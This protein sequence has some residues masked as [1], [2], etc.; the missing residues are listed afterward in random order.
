M[1]KYL[2]G[3]L[4]IV[5][6]CCVVQV[7]DRFQCCPNVGNGIETLRNFASLIKDNKQLSKIVFRRD[8]YK[9]Y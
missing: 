1:T 2:A 7:E 5:R 9:R 4:V 3:E 6:L 8:W